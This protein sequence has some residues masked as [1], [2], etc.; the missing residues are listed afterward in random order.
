MSYTIE[1]EQHATDTAT[2]VLT[3]QACRNVTLDV[4]T[5]RGATVKDVTQPA[6][7]C[8]NGQT[9]SVE[10]GAPDGHTTGGATILALNTLLQ[11]APVGIEFKY[12]VTSDP[13]LPNAALQAFSGQ[14]QQQVCFSIPAF[15]LAGK[16]S[17]SR[18]EPHRGPSPSRVMEGIQALLRISGSGVGHTP[19]N[20]PLYK[21]FK[22]LNERAGEA[23]MDAA[24]LEVCTDWA[25]DYS[26]SYQ[27]VEPNTLVI[28]A[29]DHQDPGDYLV[30]SLTGTESTARPF[31]L[32]NPHPAGSPAS[33]LV[34]VPYTPLTSYG[35]GACGQHRRRDDELERFG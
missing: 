35:G 33:S 25:T 31:D 16:F 20:L 21:T 29:V 24:E 11:L 13:L 17:R 30:T 27:V 2:I 12:Q 23:I 1:D 6:D 7:W 18:D 15:S 9:S 4:A 32:R 10:A 3:V 28:D 19:R 8:S 22:A 26:W 14:R 34:H 5:A